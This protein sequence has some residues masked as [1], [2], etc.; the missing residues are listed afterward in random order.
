MV[1]ER[2][3]S[4]DARMVMWNADGSRSD[5]CGNALR[6][7][8]L[9]LA[10]DHGHGAANAVAT[11]SGVF[12]T[13]VVT[14]N[15]GVASVR[16]SVGRPVRTG[17]QVI[18]VEGVRVRVDALRVGNPVCVIWTDDVAAAPVATVGPHLEVHEA[19]PDGTNVAFA[20]VVDRG[21]VRQRTWERGCG[22]TLACG[23]GAAAVCASG[24]LS[25][26][27]DRAVTVALPGG[28][29]ALE[30]PADEAEVCLT[31]PARVVFEGD[32]PWR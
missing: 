21:H 19:F 28:P 10:R 26:R 3:A 7:V 32:W 4:S 31:G 29:L 25:G 13:E 12:A 27:L 9:V 5:M 1:I 23:T 17:E 24:V 30:W 22:E 11:D 8:A 6:C 18:E 2:A 20:E 16:T 15:G 14:L